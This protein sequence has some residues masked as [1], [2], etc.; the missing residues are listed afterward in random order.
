M[1]RINK[2]HYLSVIEAIMYALILLFFFLESVSPR[3]EAIAAFEHKLR[4]I[5]QTQTTG[6]TVYN[7]VPDLQGE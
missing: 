2:R 6:M 5:T 7:P 3:M 1:E 4:G